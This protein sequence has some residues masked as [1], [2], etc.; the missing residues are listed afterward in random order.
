MSGEAAPVISLRS[1]EKRYGQVAA[2]Q[3]L[4]LDIHRGEIFGFLGPNGAGKTTTIRIV[5]GL[6]RA[7]GGTAQVFGLDAWRDRVETKRRLAYLPDVG[8]VYDTLS[9]HEVLEYLGRLSGRAD[10]IRRR[11]LCARLELSQGD[12]GRKVRTYSRGMKRK[13][14]IIQALEPA[15]ELVIMDEPTEGLDP[16]MQQ[17]LFELLKEE[18]RKG[19]TIFMSSH[20]LAEVEELCHRVGILRR[21]ALVALDTMQAL[22]RRKVRRL[23]VVLRDGAATVATL[24]GTTV[25]E[26][27]GDRWVLAV[28]G[29]VNAVVRALAHADL[30]DVMFE[31]ASLEDV[32]LDFYRADAP[33]SKE[34]AR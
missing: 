34:A 15:P 33:A 7:S 27:A 8:D 2:L 1:L 24:P 11:Q 23:E 32:F 3:G 25:L 14:G 16:L 22:R 6:L 18:Q 13:V 30:L 26:H 9:G 29:D 10:P 5:M 19:A 17:A 21:G 12:L 31:Q 28:Q 4:S 20:K